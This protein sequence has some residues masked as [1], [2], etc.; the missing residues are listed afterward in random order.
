MAHGLSAQEKAHVRSRLGAQVKSLEAHARDAR[1]RLAKSKPGSRDSVN[2]SV[3]VQLRKP[4][5]LQCA[6]C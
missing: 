6:R 2:R 1:S 4:I 3:E 5:W